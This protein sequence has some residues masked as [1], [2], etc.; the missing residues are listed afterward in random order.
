[1]T[2]TVNFERFSEKRKPFFKKLEYRFLVESGKIENAT[3]QYKTALSI[4]RQTEWVVQNGPIAKN[5]I[6]PVTIYFFRKNFFSLRTRI[7]S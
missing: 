4:L 5:G 6:L 1:M 2:I 7:K 3:F